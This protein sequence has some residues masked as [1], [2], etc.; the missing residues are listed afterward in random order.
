MRNGEEDLQSRGT[1]N[2]FR[3]LGI[4]L[5]LNSGGDYEAVYNYQ[6]YQNVHHMCILLHVNYISNWRRGK[7][8]KISLKVM[9]P[10]MQPNSMAILV[11]TLSYFFNPNFKLQT[12]DML[13]N[14]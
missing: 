12:R 2:I 11:L 8:V 6:N 10:S 1:R 9:D 7:M 4:F 3:M 13:S 5:Y 14:Q